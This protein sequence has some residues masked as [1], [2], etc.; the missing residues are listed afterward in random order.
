[1]TSP[2]TDPARQSPARM[3]DRGRGVSRVTVS[4]V[5]AVPTGNVVS[6]AIINISESIYCKEYYFFQMMS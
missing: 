3:G 2:R 6:F 4:P 5:L 1:M